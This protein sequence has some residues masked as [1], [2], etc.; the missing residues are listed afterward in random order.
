V[1]LNVL[2]MNKNGA[3]PLSLTLTGN[4]AYV[5]A[6]GGSLEPGVTATR[7]VASV[8]GVL[9]FSGFG[10]SWTYSTVRNT[11][12]QNFQRLMEPLKQSKRI[13][14]GGRQEIKSI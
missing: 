10:V 1:S 6:S 8:N 9:G 3:F 14:A 2:V 13:E 11:V 4:D 12:M 7:L 5:Y